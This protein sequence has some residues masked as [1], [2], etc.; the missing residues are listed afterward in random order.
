MAAIKFIVQSK[1]KGRLAT[2]YLRFC[3]SREVN[4]MVSTPIKVYPGYW[5]NKTATINKS[6]VADGLFTL[7]EKTQIETD[8]NS[9]KDS[10]L[11]SYNELIKISTAPTKEWLTSVIDKHY[12]KET[13]KEITLNQYIDTFIKDAET[14]NRLYD[15]NG[16][17]K[18]YEKGTIK[19]YKGFQAQFDA[20]QKEKKIRLNF[21][22]ITI[23]F[24]DE[25]VKYF[26]KKEYSIN[27][28]GRHIKS[29]KSIM[30][31]AREEGLHSNTEID[32]K[33]FKV[34]KTQVE[35]IYLTELEVYKIKNFDFSKLS[36]KQI[37]I[38]Q[39][40]KISNISHLDQARDVFLI[41]C[42]TAQRFSDFS[43]IRPAHIKTMASG[44]KV[45]DLIQQKT[46]ERVVIPIRPELDEI[47]KKYNYQVPKTFEQKINERIKV[48]GE[49]AGITETVIIE[50]NKGGYKVKNDVKKNE[51]IKTH[52]ARRTGCTL[53]Y[54][55]GVPTLDIMKISGH[56]TER[57][58]LNYIKVGKEETAQNLAKH[59]YFMGNP[60][61]IAK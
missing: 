10:I 41:G 29:L 11:I 32:R 25:Y 49:L 30:R 14:G 54:L 24:Y 44:L 3:T 56:K 42:Y 38:L 27:T 46:G 53:M 47:L 48:I 57:E 9:L 35:N 33:K 2:V 16:I 36:P 61:K 18:R 1:E 4:I 31:C 5:S 12:N 19:N 26:T 37:A 13:T 39:K 17:T 55:A 43:K 45:I 50:E 21:D 15:H 60:L 7:A 20:Y 22:H 8:L 58:F 59:P 28:I 34:L 23:D 52:T 51:L 40:N 6:I